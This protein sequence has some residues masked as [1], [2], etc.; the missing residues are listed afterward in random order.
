MVY[1]DQDFRAD[2]G[3]VPRRDILKWGNGIQ[4]IA[5]PQGGIF[6]THGFRALSVMFWRPSLDYKKTDHRY[7]LSWE[8]DFRNQASAEV[9]FTNNFIFLTQD[10]DPTG[11]PGAIPLPGNQGYHFN[12]VSFEYQS[13]NSNILTYGGTATIGRFFN[14]EISSVGGQVGLRIQPKAQIS[15]GLDY[16]GIRLPDPYAD[17]D[18]FFATLRSEI[19]FSKS[20]F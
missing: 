3:F 13:N 16:N 15:V 11:T 4:Y 17:A 9:S 10:F 12:Q 2:L 14:G 20:V 6:N 7:S 18:I 1:I 8:T 19:T 5:Y